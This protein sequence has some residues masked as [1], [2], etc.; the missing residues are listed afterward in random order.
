MCD[1]FAEKEQSRQEKGGG[2]P[3]YNSLQ[4]RHA[5]SGQNL[6]SHLQIDENKLNGPNRH[7]RI[8]KRSTTQ[9]K[10]HPVRTIL[11]ERDDGTGAALVNQDHLKAL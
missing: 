8:V 2:F 5:N 3:A 6:T 7:T 4:H 10:L 11:D 9:E 1:H